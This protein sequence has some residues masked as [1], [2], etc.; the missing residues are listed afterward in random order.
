MSNS[1]KIFGI[2][3]VSLFVLMYLIY[4]SRQ[5]P[6]GTWIGLSTSGIWCKCSGLEYFHPLYSDG[7]RMCF[8][9][10]HNCKITPVYDPYIGPY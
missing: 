3:F 9:I 1:I 10:K 8:G 6:Q 2:F 7:T 5:A 4:P